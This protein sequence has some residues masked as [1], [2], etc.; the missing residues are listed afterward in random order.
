MRKLMLEIVSLILLFLMPF[1]VNTAMGQSSSFS[2]SNSNNDTLLYV[3]DDGNIGIGLQTPG[4][5]LHIG[6]GNFL[7]EGGG[8]TAIIMKRDITYRD[9]PS[10]ISQNPIF[11]LGRII[12]A[13][14]KDPEFRVLYS[15]DNTLERSVFE[16]DRKGIVASVKQDRGSHFEGFIT[17][18]DEE[19]VF[20]LNSYP[21]MRFEMGE[22]GSDSV[23]VAMQRESANTLT[24]ITDKTERLR[25]DSDGNIGIGTTSPSNILTVAHG[26]I[27]DPIADAWTTYSSRRW[28]MNI[29]TIEDA[30]DKVLHLRG[31]T[32]DWKTDGKHDIGLIAEEV[33]EIIPEIVTYEENGV[34][35]KSLDYSRLV[36][37]L[38]EA[39]KE[40]QKI[41][42]RQNKKMERFESALQRLEALMI[43]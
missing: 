35:A 2:I 19:P 10:G 36:A 16:F 14:D 34:D 6:D 37:V 13:G 38:I 18:N 33:G 26:S 9:G 17:G 41:I 31:V 32:Y 42:E 3:R 11:H 7:I 22:G 12:E 27:T 15:D 5:K 20:R 4:Q 21:K 23:D 24:F 28:K 43:N 25:I 40:Q 1:M 30:I 39:V 8:E 29:N